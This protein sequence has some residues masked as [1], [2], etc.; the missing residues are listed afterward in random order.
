MSARTVKAQKEI[1]GVDFPIGA[2]WDAGFIPASVSHRRC[3][4]S[5][6]RDGRFIWT[7][8]AVGYKGSERLA[9]WDV[10]HFDCEGCAKAFALCLVFNDADYAEC[11]QH[12]NTLIDKPKLISAAACVLCS[13]MGIDAAKF[14]MLFDAA[15][16]RIRWTAFEI[17]DGQLDWL[18]VIRAW[19]S[20]EA[21]AQCRG[22]SL[23]GSISWWMSEIQ[24]LRSS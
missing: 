10:A 17:V 9:S 23:N 2:E 3:R 16:H 21:E 8:V 22:L 12:L 20:T 24:R 11:S 15:K 5:V 7:V 13:L 4:V 14:A 1:L 6:R 18:T 19:E